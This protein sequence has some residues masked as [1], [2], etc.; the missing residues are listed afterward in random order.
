M[1]DT[2]LRTTQLQ[3]YEDIIRKGRRAFVEV[4]EALMKIRSGKL[5][6]D[7]GFDTFEKYCLERWGYKRAMAHQL[8]DASE[9]SNTLDISSVRQAMAVKQIPK[10]ERAEVMERVYER[11]TNTGERVTARLITEV[12]SGPSDPKCRHCALHCP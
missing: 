1:S 2:S 12:A 3:A 10:A 8:I 11:A 4:G 6:K 7:A 9:M 5:Y